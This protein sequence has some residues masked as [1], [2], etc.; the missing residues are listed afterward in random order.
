MS[1]PLLQALAAAQAGAPTAGGNVQKT[2]GVRFADA[3]SS[4]LQ[5]VSQSQ[6]KTADLQRQF[7]LDVDGVSLERTM[8]AMQESQIAFQGALTVRNRLVS[9]YTDI[10]NMT[11]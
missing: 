5:S 8:I 11:V 4:A 10:M 6:F 1:T 2:G 9:A 3:L 7:Q